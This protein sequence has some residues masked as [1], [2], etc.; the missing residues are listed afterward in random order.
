MIHSNGLAIAPATVFGVRRLACA[1]PREAGFA[2]LKRQ[3][4]AALQVS[5]PGLRYERMQ[6]KRHFANWP[7]PAPD[8]SRLGMDSHPHMR[9]LLRKGGDSNFVSVADETRVLP[10]ALPTACQRLKPYS[11]NCRHISPEFTVIRVM[12]NRRQCVLL[13]Y[14]FIRCR[15]PPSGR[16]F[17]RGPFPFRPHNGGNINHISYFNYD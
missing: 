3:R 15:P 13:I 4:A 8:S 1:F 7:I 9:S 17:G 2:P 6:S 12:T 16:A 14:W 5:Y 10:E 11:K